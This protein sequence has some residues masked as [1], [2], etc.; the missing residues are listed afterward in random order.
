MKIFQEE[1]FGPVLTV[2]TFR[3]QSEA[4][5][6]ANNTVYGLGNGVWTKDI[7][8][9]ILVSEKLRSGTVYVNT[10]FETTL[11]YHSEA[12]KRVV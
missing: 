11:K 7:D 9:A 12:I 6:L 1:I 4:V 8:K 2:T 3:E 10:Y 5:D